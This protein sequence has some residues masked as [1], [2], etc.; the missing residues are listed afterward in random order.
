MKMNNF[1]LFKNGI[2]FRLKRRRYA[3]HRRG[4]RRL[5]LFKSKQEPAL[6]TTIPTVR[7]GSYGF[8]TVTGTRR[9][10]VSL[11][12]LAYQIKMS[13]FRWMNYQPCGNF[14]LKRRPS[15]GYFKVDSKDRIWGELADEKVFKA[16]AKRGNAEMQNQNLTGHVY[17]LKLAGTY[18]LTDDLYI[19]FIHP[20]ER[21]QEP[22]LGEK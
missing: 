11:W 14:G 4:C 8:G 15:N 2:T 9:D 3:C 7:I 18:I 20:S 10:L 5:W 1:I 19:G 13:L 22:R 6:T 17:R 16:M 12:M 21:F